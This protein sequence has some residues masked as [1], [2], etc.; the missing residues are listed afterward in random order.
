VLRTIRPLGEDDIVRGQFRGYREEP[1]VASDSGVATF[2]A[3]R[4]HVDSWRWQGVPFYV[5]TG[6]ALAT[7]GT[8]VTVELK[9][10]PPVVFREPPP[11]M[12]NY[13]RFRLN[14]QVIVALGARG[15]RPGPGMTGEDVELSVVEHPAQGSGGR[16]EAYERLLS[17]AMAGD[18]TLFAREDVVEAAWAIVEPVLR[19]AG[20][21]IAYEPGTWGPPQ[22][23][24][25]VADV[26][27]WNFKASPPA[28]PT[29]ENGGTS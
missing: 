5:R 23:D 20:S 14:P 10:P 13:V 2:A 24:A 18:A 29:I 8:E 9:A 15:K 12:G 19:P 21:P 22:A 7:T 26:G 25:L 11:P 17:D 27:G 3:L 6:K 16:M 28:G 4:L 1:G